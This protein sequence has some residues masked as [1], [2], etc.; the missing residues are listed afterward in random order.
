MSRFCPRPKVNPAFKVA[1]P[2]PALM[3]ALELRPSGPRR[4]RA[5]APVPSPATRLGLPAMRLEEKNLNPAA[6][7][8]PYISLCKNFAFTDLPQV[9]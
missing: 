7:P 6:E 3:A 2:L 4:A 8:N 5:A 1:Q 9:V